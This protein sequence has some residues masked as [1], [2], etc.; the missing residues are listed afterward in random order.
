MFPINF[1]YFTFTKDNSMKNL[2]KNFTGRELTNEQARYRK[3]KAAKAMADV[4]KLYDLDTTDT[5]KCSNC[6][7]V[8]PPQAAVAHVGSPVY[9]CVRCLKLTCL[10]HMR[11][12]NFVTH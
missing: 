6:N 4:S 11:L 7:L 1:I 8:N 3:T 12:S 9:K 10:T 2:A 5:I